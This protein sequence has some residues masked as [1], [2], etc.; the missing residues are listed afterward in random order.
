MSKP[1]RFYR[2]VDGILLLDK[3]LGLT[4]NAALQQARIAFGARKAGHAGSLDPLASGLLPICFGQA[5]KVCGRLLDSSKT[6]AV[7]VQL[8]ARTESLD[9]ETE[10]VERA[11]IPP[12]DD[13]KLDAVLAG[14]LGEQQQIPPM[15]SALKHA[16]ERLYELAR[17]GESVERPPRRILIE[18]IRRTRPLDASTDLLEFEVHCSKG[19]Y[20]RSLAADIAR[21]LG[22]LG[23]VTGLR[24]L[25]V[26]PFAGLAMVTLPDLEIGRRCGTAALDSLLL[27]AD[28]A[29]LDLVR[30]D[31][32]AAGEAGLLQGRTVQTLQPAP[33]GPLRAYAHG[34][35]LGLVAGQSDGRVHPTRLFVGV[36]SAAAPAPA[37]PEPSTGAAGGGEVVG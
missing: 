26:D 36:S 34:R 27:G 28:A 8:G 23:Y 7:A 18:R 15:H 37:G 11:P 4:S 12:L 17:R 6:Y 25:S 33:P 9:C 22:T 20:I 32:D 13:A 29:F 2:D 24:R 31:L 10:V 30:I 1:R 16:G 35:F 5:T 3:P 19:T 14:F 21:S